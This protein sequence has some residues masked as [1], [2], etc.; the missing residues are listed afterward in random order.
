VVGVCPCFVTED[1]FESRLGEVVKPAFSVE[2]DAVSR[3]RELT[4]V[5]V[6]A[7]L[8]DKDVVSL[9]SA[10]ANAFEASS[11]KAAVWKGN[12]VS[13]ESCCSVVISSSSSNSRIEKAEGKVFQGI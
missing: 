8:G 6:Y 10:S 12:M 5:E 4:A 3:P 9:Q 2:P 13:G 7:T 1:D 11:R